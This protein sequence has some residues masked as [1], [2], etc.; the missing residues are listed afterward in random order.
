M[1]TYLFASLWIVSHVV[2]LAIAR[3]RNVRMSA[4]ST[5]FLSL[6][7]PFAI[8][9]VLAARPDYAQPRRARETDAP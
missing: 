1:T 9:L 2:C 7:G 3:R 5:M 6:V 8:P 4:L